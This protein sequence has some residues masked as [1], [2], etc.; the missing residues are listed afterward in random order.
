M[1][2]P[3]NTKIDV[4]VK[5]LEFVGLK[6]TETKH[7]KI[8]EY[9]KLLDTEKFREKLRLEAKKRGVSLN[10]STFEGSYVFSP[11]ET[12]KL[13]YL[14]FEHVINGKVYPFGYFIY[15]NGNPIP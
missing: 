1:T 6:M 2:E 15:D 5:L 14:P 13:H 8:D 3:K 9:V 7:T 4:Y 11:P 12:P 10:R